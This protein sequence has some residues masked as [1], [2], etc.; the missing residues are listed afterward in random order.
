[1]HRVRWWHLA[2][3][4]ALL[5][6]ALLV[7]SVLLADLPD[8]RRA[9]GDADASTATPSILI[10]D[11]HDRLLYEVIDPAGSK[12]VPLALDQIPLACQQ[13][14]IATEDSR[15]YEHPGVDLIAIGR[16][17][18]QN[19]R[20][21]GTVSGASTLT[22][23]VARTL[24]L[25]AEERTEQTLRRKLREAWLALRLEARYSKD[26]ILALY[27]N[28]TY[29]GHFAVGIE[30]AAQA[31]FGMHASELD[32]AQCTLLAGLPQYPAGYNPIENPEAAQARQAT[33]L[34][35]MVE[36]G[37]LTASQAQDA[38]NERLAYAGTPFPIAA[39]HF[40]M[41]VQ[42][43][44]ET[45]LPAE[46]VRLGGL[47]VTTTL[48]LDWQR[49]AEEA[50]QRRLAQLRPCAAA[51]ERGPRRDVRRGRRSCASRR[52]CRTGGVGS[53][54]RRGAGVGG[55]PG[56]FRSHHQRRGQ[57][58]SQPPPAR[59]RHQAAHLRGRAGP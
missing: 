55:Q 47:R 48:D 2:P 28:D 45:L 11:R 38:S 36:Q 34:R 32:L 53:L 52:E 33:V 59:L 44:L 57:R 7:Y 43:Q 19:W 17:A 56:L 54:H 31:Y 3:L 16:A 50:V 37:H 42:G 14:T 18:W 9:T 51:S 20:G 15:F 12:H 30:A 1:M 27:L 4:G 35:L 23:Q 58:C 39:P 5:A 40:V 22:Q 6:G 41:W 21:G 46:Q 24:Y 25:S 10:T 26:E 29:Y 49:A 8:P 13:A